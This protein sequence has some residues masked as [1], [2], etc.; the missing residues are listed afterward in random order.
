MLGF[1]VLQ[2][3]VGSNLALLSILSGLFSVSNL[4]YTVNNDSHIP[5]QK[6]ENSF[7]VDDKFKRSVFAGSISGCV[8][9]LLPGLGPAQGT[10]IAQSLTL[11]K[12]VSPEE[13][14]ITNSGVN[15]SDTLFS[16]IA[17]YLI[18]NPRSAIS[19]YVSN[20]LSEVELIHIIFFIFV[21]LITVSVCCMLSIKV[22]DWM[23]DHVL[24]IDYKKFNLFIIILISSILVFF[25]IC[26][27]GCLWY[28]ILCYV[29]SIS[30]G[31]VC[32]VLD[33]SKSNLMGVLIVPSILTYLGII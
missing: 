23:I 29:T 21:C 26:N 19:V 13:F 15:I 7:L 24:K 28:V 22:G 20:I 2:S 12:N 32:N 9:G 11:N 30:L 25:T 31:L 6:E 1:F 5:P 18:N 3:N 8:L 33:L 4:I 27:N 16:L 10:L 17:I 14:I